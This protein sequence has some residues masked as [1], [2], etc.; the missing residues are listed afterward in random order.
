MTFTSINLI[1]T[2]AGICGWLQTHTHIHIQYRASSDWGE[3]NAH[4]LK[5]VKLGSG[6]REKVSVEC[7]SLVS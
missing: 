6:Y 2:P 5:V 4:F 3:G 7:F 1:R